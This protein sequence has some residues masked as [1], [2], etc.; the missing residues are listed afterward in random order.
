M[1]KI[2]KVDV[3]KAQSILTFASCSCGTCICRNCNVLIANPHEAEV[4]SNAWN[5]ALSGGYLK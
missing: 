4:G 3:K 1:K 2:Q 5:A